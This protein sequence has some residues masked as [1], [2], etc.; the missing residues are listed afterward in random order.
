MH[1]DNHLM[2]L[3]EKTGTFVN[4]QQ[5]NGNRSKKPR[6]RVATK[7]SQA[8]DENDTQPPGVGFDRP[9]HQTQIFCILQ[10]IW[11][12]G[13]GLI[14][15]PVEGAFITKCRITVYEK[16][17]VTCGLTHAQNAIYL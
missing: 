13:Q 9:Q 10:I 1:S 12:S 15:F 2:T 16:K 3:A 7:V 17:L 8:V 5:R 11:V 4:N 6:C 14:L